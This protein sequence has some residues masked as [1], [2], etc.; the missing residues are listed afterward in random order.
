MVLGSPSS[1][2][3]ILADL[4]VA[5]DYGTMKHLSE[6]RRL[7][8]SLWNFRLPLSEANGNVRSDNEKGAID[9]MRAG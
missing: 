8:R 9:G 3:S 5:D 7:D 4:H 1:V 6:C 2:R